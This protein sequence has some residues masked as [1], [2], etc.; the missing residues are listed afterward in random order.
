MFTHLTFLNTDRFMFHE[1]FSS[2]CEFLNGLDVLYMLADYTY[3][4][5]GIVP[6]EDGARRRYRVSYKQLWLT[7]KTH[8]N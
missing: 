8:L 3:Y 5:I 1:Y 6:L 4:F 7:Y 2:M